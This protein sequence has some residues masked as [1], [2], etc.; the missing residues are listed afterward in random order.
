M[1]VFINCPFDEAYEPLIRAAVFAVYSCGFAPQC[2]KGES[3]QNLRFQRIL[4]MI[5]ECR[6]GIHDLS[7]IEPNAL[8]RNNMP[9]ELGVFIGCQQFG[10]S[11]DY[12]KEYLILDSD[13]HRYTQHTSDVRADD[14]QYHNN[15]PNE[16]ITRVRNW[17]ASRPHRDR[18]H[19]IPGA[20]WLIE[21][22]ARFQRDAPD[23]CVK[24]LLNFKQLQYHEFLIITEAWLEHQRHLYES[25]QQIIQPNPGRTN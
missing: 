10:S 19:N 16:M 14:A 3:N 5:G 6:Y 23:L 12:E 11:Y 9:L 18:S 22:Y 15:D 4:A 1:N 8:P 24:L 17:L 2:A 13:E 25:F 7:R 20:E 21:R